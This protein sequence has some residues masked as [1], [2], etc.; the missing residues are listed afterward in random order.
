[1]NRIIITGNG[2][3]IAHGLLTDYRDFINHIRKDF[4]N[5]VNTNTS[6][7]IVNG[8]PLFFVTPADPVFTNGSLP[9]KV[10]IQN[11][12]DIT[13]WDEL[14]KRILL[15]YWD[16]NV[17]NAQISVTNHFLNFALIGSQTK[18]WGGF[19]NDYKNILTGIMRGETTAGKGLFPKT[20]TAENLN[21]DLDQVIELLY[22]YLKNKII[23][24]DTLDPVILSRLLTKPLRQWGIKPGY[25][26]KYGTIRSIQKKSG[27]TDV[28]ED[29]QLEDV[30]FLSFN[31][32]S[33]IR[34]YL[35]R[36]ANFAAIDNCG[37]EYS[38]KR[39]ISTSLRCIHGDLEDGSH[40]SLIF[41]YGDELDENQ[42]ILETLDDEFLRHI[43]SVLYT[44]SP[45]YREV[46]EFAESGE[47]DIII[48][49]HSCSNTDRTLLNTLF[50][51]KNCV[52][53]QPF[54]HNPNTSSIYTNIYRCFKDKTLMRSR[55][56]DQTNTIQ[57]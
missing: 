7:E 30:L 49:G 53:I 13:S 46:I 22:D 38:S 35:F 39:R 1:M 44:R 21:K 48:Y 27:F 28:Q 9:R 4:I 56:V 23:V 32:T 36:D 3:D 51:H 31:Y 5:F 26:S 45:Y 11:G 8:H 12:E 52:S 6:E 43:K 54:L 29:E 25:I 37:L 17:Y 40:N 14:S 50:E 10:I 2:F 16:G 33:T 15:E 19:E 55:V 42:A 47:F 24:P 41:G 34:N 57:G 20:Y 18:S